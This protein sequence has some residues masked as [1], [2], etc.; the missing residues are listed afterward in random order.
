MT[1]FR[2][3]AREVKAAG[4]AERGNFEPNGV[5]LKAYKYWARNTKSYRVPVR[6]NFC[7]FW[8]VVAIWAPLMFLR[9]KSVDFVES[10]TGMVIIGLAVIAAIVF[11]G[12]A[13][14]DFRILLAVLLGVIFTVTG[15]VA[16]I[17]FAAGEE[18]DD[19]ER[20]FFKVAFVLGLPA[21]LIAFGIT[22]MALNWNKDWNEPLADFFLKVAPF[23]LGGVGIFALIAFGL[24][25]GWL[26]LLFGIGLALAFVALIVVMI[27]GVSALSDFLSGRR[28]L[29]RDK[30]L[31]ADEAYYAE[32]GEFPWQKTKTK[33]EP[34][35]V[36]KFFSGLADLIIFV[37]QIVRVKKWKICPI[38]TISE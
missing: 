16:G 28:A 3:K 38:V 22:K 36:A 21:A 17:C 32:H 26:W 5:P 24:T 25:A 14:V 35:K 23:V 15:G 31:E 33:R 10:K 12:V 2:D 7:H 19:D 29:A 8:R 13:S 27:I 30:A 6:E 18:L 20:I 34:G 4:E 11:G 1:N 9:K 37:S